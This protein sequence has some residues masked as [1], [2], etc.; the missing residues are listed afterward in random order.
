MPLTRSHAADKETPIT[1]TICDDDY[2]H[3]VVPDLLFG[4]SREC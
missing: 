4:H 2:S 1:T 3:I